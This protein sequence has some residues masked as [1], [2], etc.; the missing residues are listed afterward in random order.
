MQ[1]VYPRV[2]LD[3]HCIGIELTAAAEVYE[4]FYAVAPV[5]AADFTLDDSGGRAEELLR[6][7]MKFGKPRVALV[8]S[9]IS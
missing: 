3:H 4:R 9:A 1:W 7:S 6:N 2:G 5:A 8:S